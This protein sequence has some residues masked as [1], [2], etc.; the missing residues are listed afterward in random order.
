MRGWEVEVSRLTSN[1]TEVDRGTN[2]AIG[3]ATPVGG[4]TTFGGETGSG[5]DT[6]TT[7]VD[8]TG[9]REGAVEV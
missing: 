6:D 5:I 7:G 4:S 1:T 2:T 9:D 8:T 3:N